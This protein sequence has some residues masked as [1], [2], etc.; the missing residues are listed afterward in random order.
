MSSFNRIH[1]LKTLIFALVTLGLGVALL[2]LSRYV[3]STPSLDWL[4][5]W[6]IAELGG[7]LTGAGLLGIGYDYI[8]GRDK[9]A[10][11]EERTRRLLKDAAP[12]FRDAVVKG[13]AVS[14]DDLRRVATPELL[15]GIATNAMALRLD[16]AMFA[17]EVYTDIRDQAVG[18]SER[19]YDVKVSIRISRDPRTAMPS[20]ISRDGSTRDAAASTHDRAPGAMTEPEPAFVVTARWEYTVTP[21][22]AIQRFACVSDKDEYHELATDIPTTIP[23]F[24]TPR[25]GYAASDREAFELLSYSIDGKQLPIRRSERKT[26]QTYSVNLGDDTVTARREVKVAY[27]VKTITAQSGHLLHFDVE[28]PTRNISVDFDYTEAGIAHAS[29]LDLIASAKRARI[30]R[31]PHSVPGKT[32]SID[33][34]GWV[35]PRTGFAFIWTLDEEAVRTPVPVGART[36]HRD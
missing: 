27:V 33:F 24:M 21:S 15:D 36:A 3:D 17:S 11:D 35:F 2:V 28:Q 6:P 32:I 12:D 10:L 5:L 7:I 26:G 16:D 18:A 23:W 30:E 9:D 25:P 20:P 8:T 31:L 4:S 13:F 34:D 14:P 1:R 19:W 29:V 22:H